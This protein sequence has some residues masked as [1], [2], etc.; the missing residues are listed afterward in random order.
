MTL[1][2][3]KQCQHCRSHWVSASPDEFTCPLC[4]REL[5]WVERFLLDNATR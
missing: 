4:A 5:E 3:D 2:L 1:M